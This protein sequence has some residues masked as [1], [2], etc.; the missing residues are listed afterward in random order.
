MFPYFLLHIKTVYIYFYF[1]TELCFEMVQKLNCNKGLLNISSNLKNRGIDCL[2]SPYFPIFP[3]DSLD[4][5]AS[6]DLPSSWFV[7]ARVS[8]LPRGAGV[9]FSIAREGKRNLRSGV[10][11][12]GSA[13]VW[14]RESRRSGEGR[15]KEHLIQLLDE[16]SAA[17]CLLT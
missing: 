15:K 13:K 9:G 12:L 4:W 7:Q 11:F 5:Y 10:L 1:A 3:W 17:P 16:S 2:Q 14:Q 6:M 8:K